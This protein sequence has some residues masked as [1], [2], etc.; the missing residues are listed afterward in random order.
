MFEI[1]LFETTVQRRRYSVEAA[2]REEAE[3]LA[4]Q[5]NST[6]EIDLGSPE[7]TNRELSCSL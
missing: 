6:D 3:Q 4:M 1:D 7:T 5:G 2:T